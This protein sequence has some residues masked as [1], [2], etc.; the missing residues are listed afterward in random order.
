MKTEEQ[1]W[2]LIVDSNPIPDVN[3][4]GRE[5]AEA[6]TYLATLAQRSSE[7]TQVDTKLEETKNSK[8]H[9]L[10][11]LVAAV[12]AIV[13]GVAVIQLS[14]SD[15]NV[16]ASQPTPSTEETN[17]TPGEVLLAGYATAVTEGD[18]DGVMGHYLSNPFIIVKRHPYAA[19]DF[20]DRAT[21]VREFESSVPGFL[22]SDGSLE[23]FDMVPGDPDSV[24]QPDVTFSWRFNYSADSDE[25]T[26]WFWILEGAPE[27][28]TGE[29][30]CIGGRDAKVFITE[31][32]IKEINWG[33]RDI[34]KCDS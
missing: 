31:G 27:F 8:R 32:K 6:T 19:G 21:E 9:G 11:W 25:P 4:Y 29:A 15:N 18:I 16:P 23:I 10:T 22:G 28:S 13:A 7:M 12:L 5:Q 24:V 17:A 20:M 26:G 34:T 2:Q 14:Q 30:G 3:V 33:F 1:V